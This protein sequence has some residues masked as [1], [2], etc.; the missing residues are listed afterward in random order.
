M[1]W[2]DDGFILALRRH[3]ETS[4]IL[5]VLTRDHGRH[6]GLCRGAA[7]G[8]SR[9]VF[10]PGSRVR[11]TWR[12]RV[13]DALG[14]FVCEP[15]AA[16]DPHLLDDALRLQALSAACAVLETT[17][18]E[19]EAFS[20]AFDRF[21]ALLARLA[22]GDAWP[23]A[24]VRWELA[25]L[26]DLGFGLDLSH[27]AVTGASRD[28]AFVSPKSGRAVS[29][30]AGLPYRDKLLALPAFLTRPAARTA[31][32]EATEAS[33]A[34]GL[35]LTGHFLERHVY[36]GRRQGTPPARSRL[37]ARFRSLCAPS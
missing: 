8:R 29:L 22:A 5:S 19:R 4:A 36:A 28:L 37:A 25:L 32:A 27:C 10:Q 34:A 18:P 23:E 35:D 31:G 6:H 14:S 33:V 11:V 15:V 13:A 2:T 12:S 1:L 20:G 16:L 17:L 30:E 7:G 26:A 24:Y 3:G 21:E 9:G